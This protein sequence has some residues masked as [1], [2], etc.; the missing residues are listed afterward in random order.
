MTADQTAE[1]PRCPACTA[2]LEGG[3][4][5]YGDHQWRLAND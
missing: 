3:Y 2:E 1:T 5:P 4:C